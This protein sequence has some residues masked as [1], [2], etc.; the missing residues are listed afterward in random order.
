MASFDSESHARRL[1]GKALVMDRPLPLQTRLMH[2]RIQGGASPI[3]DAG[4]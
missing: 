4:H 1:A 2:V 3:S